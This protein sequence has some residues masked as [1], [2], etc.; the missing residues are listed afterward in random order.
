MNLYHTNPLMVDTDG[1][2]IPD[3]AEIYAGTDPNR[4]DSYFRVTDI[5]RTPT[6]SIALTWP[7]VA[8]KSYQVWRSTDI[9]F[10]SYDTIVSGLNSVASTLTYTDTPPPVGSGAVFYRVALEQ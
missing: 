9:T 7:C 1:D 10:A 6:G 5:H 3:G 2:G 8:G 4:A